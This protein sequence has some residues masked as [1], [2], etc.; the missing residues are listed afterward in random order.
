MDYII[1]G[2]FFTAGALVSYIL[3]ARISLLGKFEKMIW[4][5]LGAGKRVI[6]SMNEDAYIFELKDNRLRITKGVVDFLET[7]DIDG[8]VVDSIGSSESVNP[9]SS[10]L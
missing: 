6:V 7:T 1:N 10:V 9:D 8:N 2:L 4:T 3:F 5:G